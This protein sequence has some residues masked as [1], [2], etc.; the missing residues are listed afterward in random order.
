M[1]EDVDP[2]L[3][4]ITNPGRNICRVHA[5]DIDPPLS[6]I[7]NISLQHD[8]VDQGEARIYILGFCHV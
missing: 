6:L 5:E 8:V 3:S 7:P 2:P 4:I 1:S